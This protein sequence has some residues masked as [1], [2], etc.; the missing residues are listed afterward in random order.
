MRP[1]RLKPNP[2]LKVEPFTDWACPECFYRISD[3][4]SV[5]N[6][7]VLAHMEAH[8]KEDTVGA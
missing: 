4:R 1:T 8:D 3:E 2:T 5:V 7:A 6:Q